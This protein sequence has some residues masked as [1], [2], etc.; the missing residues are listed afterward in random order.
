MATI[1]LGF[2]SAA[3]SG[4]TEE[5]MGT[6]VKNIAGGLQSLLEGF[7]QVVTNRR[8]NQNLT[9]LM[10]TL[11]GGGGTGGTGTG[12]P[13]TGIERVNAILD[14]AMRSKDP[15]QQ[16]QL[17]NTARVASDVANTRATALAASQKARAGRQKRDVSVT[18]NDGTKTRTV[19]M[20]AAEAEQ[21]ISTNPDA[22]LGTLTNK[23]DNQIANE[24]LAQS[25]QLF[26]FAQDELNKIKAGDE[27]RQFE[28]EGDL[29]AAIASSTNEPTAAKISKRLNIN[30]PPDS[31]SRLLGR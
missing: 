15:A 7:S 1:N 30:L 6:R 22:V 13:L 2:G 11:Q 20:T 18:F 23:T 28:T 31:F 14:A 16:A 24:T 17:L 9:A 26:T 21:A 19:K 3:G 10:N 29:I 4:R 8:N 27:S 12:S 5:Q 25:P